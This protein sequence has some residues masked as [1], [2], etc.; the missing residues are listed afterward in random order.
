MSRYVLRYGSDRGDGAYVGVG[1]PTRQQDAARWIGRRA[2]RR[3]LTET[4][5]R[6]YDV[7]L[8]RLRPR[9]TLI[10]YVVRLEAP[11]EAPRWAC[12]DSSHSANV[13]HRFV[14]RRLH[15]GYAAEPVAK[16]WRTLFPHAR[17]VPVYLRTRGRR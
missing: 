1:T 5:A 13:A 15:D 6:G 12:R 9:R 7:R 14:M 10:G 17:V 3:A 8:I 16:N 11:G 2:A 4:R